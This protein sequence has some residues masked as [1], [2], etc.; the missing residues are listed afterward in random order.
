MACISTGNSNE[1][2]TISAEV[3]GEAQAQ[4]KAEIEKEEEAEGDD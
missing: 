4:A 3:R 2:Q 1:L